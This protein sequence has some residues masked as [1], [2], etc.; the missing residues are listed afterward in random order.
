MATATANWRRWAWQYA[1]PVLVLAGTLVLTMLLG[2]WLFGADDPD[3][4]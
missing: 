4:F 3:F 1:L 2:R